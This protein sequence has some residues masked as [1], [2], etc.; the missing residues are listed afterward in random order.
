MERIVLRHISGSKAGQVEEFPLTHFKELIIGRDTSATVKYDPE[1]DDLVGRQHARISQDP[2]D[3]TRFNVTDL[4]SRNGTFVNK[5]R[6]VGTVQ[7]GPGDMVQFGAGGPEF[8]F[9]LEPRPAN[10]VKPTRVGDNPTAGGPPA[11][12]VGG[13]VPQ[14][15]VPQGYGSSQGYPQQ[16]Y[17]QGPG[18]ATV[19]RM[20]TQSKSDSRNFM[21]IGAGALL[22][23]IAAVGAVLWYMQYSSSKQLASETSGRLEAL[24]A[25]GPMSPA[26]IV[27]NYTNSAV[28]IE[29]GWKLIYTPT[30]GQV[31][32]MYIPNNFKGRQIVPD[33][34]QSVAAYVMVS[35]DTI[36]PY[37]TTDSRGGRPIGGEHTGSGFTV[38]SDGFILTNRHVAATWR[39]SYQFPQDAT[40][41]IVVQGGQIA[42]DNEGNPI[43]IRSPQDWVPS[44]TKQAG[45]KLQGG[46]EGRNDYLNVTFAK[47]DLRIPAKLARVSDRHD[48]AMMKVDVPEAVSK[49]ELYDNYDAI[50][51]GDAAIVLGY[52]AVS[53]PVY[54]VTKSQD[55]FNRESKVKIVPDPTVSV[56]NIGRIIRSSESAGKDSAY[57]AFGDAYQ[58]TINSTGSGNSGGPV[59]DDR[60]RVTGIFFASSRSDAMITFAVPIRYGKELMSVSSSR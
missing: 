41:G 11:T 29:C 12:R 2:A 19:E 6:I 49:V 3:P 42:L 54:G 38:T 30:G 8:Q 46:F 40:P 36:E 27:K 20:I 33:G 35:Q 14:T 10:A 37:L 5:Q 4:N 47:N 60:G 31:Y 24:A 17:Q 55:V 57:S 45:Q 15:A 26:D 51:P 7:V 52:P 23:V 58:L 48:V 53:P 16:H 50:K 39:T 1:R 44:E 22:V 21:I 56:G 34:R 32:Q 18:K 9:D 59:F 28:Y 25:A 43:L 13:T